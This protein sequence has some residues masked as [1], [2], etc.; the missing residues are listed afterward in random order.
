M[1]WPSNNESGYEFQTLG[2]SCRLPVEFD[3]LMLVS[4]H[5]ADV[6]TDH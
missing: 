5:S 2:T 6:K 4:Y 3:G 1:A